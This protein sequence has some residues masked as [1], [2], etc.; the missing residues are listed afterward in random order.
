M[1]EGDRQIGNDDEETMDLFA[2]YYR[3]SELTEFDTL[4]SRTMPISTKY[5]SASYI[6]SITITLTADN[7]RLKRLVGYFEISVKFGEN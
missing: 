1:I 4:Y 6:M 3:P 2:E 5:V 7:F